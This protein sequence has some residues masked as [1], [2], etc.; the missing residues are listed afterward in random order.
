[1]HPVEHF[2]ITHMKN[3]R[4]EKKSWEK[5]DKKSQKRFTISLPLWYSQHTSVNMY[6]KNGK[7]NS[8]RRPKKPPTRA[9][10]K[11]VQCVHSQSRVVKVQ[12]KVNFHAFRVCE[13]QFCLLKFF[14]PSFPPPPDPTLHESHSL[15]VSRNS[16]IV[17]L[18]AAY[19]LNSAAHIESSWCDGWSEIKNGESPPLALFYN[20]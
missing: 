6:N 7:L 1:M 2:G 9:R 14:R 12:K 5:R 13:F 3:H 16:V 4:V 10:E 8:R 11:R 15:S 20:C 18:L 19:L 17:R